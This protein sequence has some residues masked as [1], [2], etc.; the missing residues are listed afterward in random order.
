MTVK[1]NAI[2]T[3]YV[4]PDSVNG[5]T[6]IMLTSV[7]MFFK[8][9]PG[10]TNLTGLRK[11]GVILSL[12]EM[13]QDSPDVNKIITR[14]T[15]RVEYDQV[16]A[17]ADATVPT[18][19]VFPSP[20]PIKTGRFYGIVMR[21]E[22][23]TYALWTNKQ[24]D[25]ILGT[26]T[27]SSGS[28]NLRD[29]RYYESSSEGQLKPL[30]DT[31]AKFAVK[32]AKYTSNNVTLEVVN[33]DYEFFTV[34]NRTKTFVGGELVYQNV[35]NGAGT[36]RIQQGNTQIIGT[37]TSFTEAQQ[38]TYIAAIT[39][40]GKVDV[41]LI[42]AVTNSTH[43]VVTQQPT[44][45]NTASNYKLPPVG[46]LYLDNP[47]KRSMILVDSSA[48]GTNKFTAGAVITGEVSQANATI[49]SINNFSIDQFIPRL[50]LTRPAGAQVNV[51]YSMAYSNGTQYVMQSQLPVSL[52]NVNE[53]KTYDALLRSR[54]NEVSDPYLYGSDRKSALAKVTMRVNQSTIGLYTSPH[55]RGT[56]LDFYTIENRVNS[57]TQ[58]YVDGLLI[59]TEVYP[60]GLAKAK[61]ISNKVVFANNRFAEDIRVYVNALRPR[62]TDVKV[63]ARVHNVA[64]PEP[65]DDKAWTPLTCIENANRYSS[66]ED[67]RDYIEYSY[68]LPLQSEPSFNINAQ[69]TTQFGN[70][71]LTTS[72]TIG[73]SFN[74]NTAINGTTEFITLAGHTFANNDQVFYTVDTGNTAISSLELD[75]A[76]HVVQANSTGIKLAATPGGTPINLTAGTISETGHNLVY[77]KTNDIVRISNSLFPENYMI[78][79]V[80]T[81]N[82][83]AIILY[84][85][86]ANN[87]LV[88]DGF[89]VQRMKYPTIAFANPSNDKVARYYTET[90]AEFDKFNSMQ[91]KV[92]LLS[93][94]TFVVPKVDQLQV[95]GVSA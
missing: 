56:D 33:R 55:L 1:Y 70:A 18:T 85:P 86:I 31:D 73:R 15:V 91:V 69:F 90:G 6:E 76:Y 11:P 43:I 26:N 22:D 10:G 78:G 27:P 75:T 66:S 9:K 94:S 32:I 68:A 39:T 3:F 21:F 14:S 80:A 50:S 8:R 36:I 72:A 82:S 62:G 52:D 74:P 61:Y 40:G 48:N 25:R 64:D 83:S 28:A 16:Y 30:S 20:L 13:T 38:G 67:P 65:F 46:Q 77:V 41:M 19:F 57:N 49:S 5:A 54:S 42:D 23:P 93:N 2:Q 12:C 47:L 79:A 4:D 87:S 95:I 59:D 60:N 58:S 51:T 92:V 37:G 63:Y 34:T 29:G 88:G 45:S 71:T 17:L 24:G 7:D 89:I 44:F 84:D 81:S 35:A 53:I